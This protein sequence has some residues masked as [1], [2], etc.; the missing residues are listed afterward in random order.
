MTD[1]PTTKN[2]ECPRDYEY[3][4]KPEWVDSLGSEIT[5][6]RHTTLESEKRTVSV[7]YSREETHD[8]ENSRKEAESEWIISDSYVMLDGDDD[9]TSL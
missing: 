6:P 1:L 2:E 8:S 9:Y 5:S 4:G 3:T 7:I